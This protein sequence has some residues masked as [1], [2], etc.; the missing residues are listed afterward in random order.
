MM[1][2][3]IKSR[4]WDV[5]LQVMLPDDYPIAVTA[6]G[7]FYDLSPNREQPYISQLAPQN[8]NLIQ[9]QFTGLTDKNGV[10]IYE[11]D[12][13]SGGE[14]VPERVVVFYNGSFRLADDLNSAD[15]TLVEYTASR[16]EVI[17]N[18]QQHP[19]LLK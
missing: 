2:R 1:S 9:L 7:E 6:K 19:E 5:N 12:L 14:N 10:D 4:F 8:L 15:Q 13:L 11:S 18:I 17:G 16:L 3:V